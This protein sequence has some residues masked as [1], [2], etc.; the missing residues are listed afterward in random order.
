MTFPDWDCLSSPLRG[1]A[2][3]QIETAW[4]LLDA[5]TTKAPVR[6]IVGRCAVFTSGGVNCWTQ[7]QLAYPRTESTTSPGP[8]PG[9]CG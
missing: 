3:D 5:S 7:P 2:S 6:S 9:R 4:F 8:S 1:C